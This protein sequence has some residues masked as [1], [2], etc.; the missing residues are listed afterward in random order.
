MAKRANQK[1]KLLYLVKLLSEESDEM[2][3]LSVQDCIAVLARHDIAAERKSIYDDM[4]M[5]RQ[6]GYDVVT[7]RGRSNSYFLGQRDFELPELKLLVDAVGSAKFITT[8]KSQELIKKICTLTSRHEG[9][10]MRRQV[11][12]SGRPKTINKRIYYNVDTIHTA[13]SENRQI[14]FLYTH[15]I[16][17]EKAPRLFENRTR[18]NGQFYGVS[19]WSLLWDDEYYYLVAWDETGGKMKH[20]RVDRMEN[21]TATEETRLGRAAYEQ[22]DIAGY[23]KSMFNMYGGQEKNVR[24]RFSN[25]LIGVAVDR[26]GPDIIIHRDDEK[27]FTL[28]AKVVISPQFFSWIF[29]LGAAAAIL[30]PQEV[31]QEMQV[32]LQKVQALYAGTESAET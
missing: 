21:I 26:F 30:E 29:G 20:Y 28:T 10:L 32:T 14:R 1:L 5:L 6:F 22:M 15:W 3:P 19:P 12:V 18:R 2:H 8:E 31:V 16:I 24:M 27:H 13:I 23:S 25:H 7:V 9:G 11:H 17:D 4:E